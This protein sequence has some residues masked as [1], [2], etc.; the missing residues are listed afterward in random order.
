[1]NKFRLL[2]PNLFQEEFKKITILI[3]EAFH[4]SKGEQNEFLVMINQ[5][6][7]TL[8]EKKKNVKLCKNLDLVEKSIKKKA[9]ILLVNKSKFIIKFH[10]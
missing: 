5:F 3:D 9:D 8:K 6:L 1:M 2:C 7:M 10:W 4:S